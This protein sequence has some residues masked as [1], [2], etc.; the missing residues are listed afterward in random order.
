M[1]Y[2]ESIKNRKDSL[3]RVRNMF[4]NQGNK[5]SLYVNYLAKY[6]WTGYKT[7]WIY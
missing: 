5:R 1:D 3:N 2:V 7:Y 4:F 6:W